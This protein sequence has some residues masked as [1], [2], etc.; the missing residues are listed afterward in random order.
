MSV[1]YHSALEQY[2]ILHSRAHN[3]LAQ[4]PSKGPR[5]LYRSKIKV[6]QSTPCGY[7][8]LVFQ[9]D[10]KDAKALKWIRS[11][12]AEKTS[13][14]CWKLDKIKYCN[15]SAVFGRFLSPGWSDQFFV[16]CIAIWNWAWQQFVSLK[17][18]V[19]KLRLRLSPTVFSPT[20]P[21]RNE[22]S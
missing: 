8:E 2:K 20:S 10:W 15:F 11:S 19:S 5:A 7:S 21:D 17:L 16:F 13:K 4:G 22:G 12:W 3:Y 18:N 9:Y 6:S 14:N 1:Q